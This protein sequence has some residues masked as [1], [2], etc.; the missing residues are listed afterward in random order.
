[1]TRSSQKDDERFFAQEAAKELGK[2][3][4]LGPDREI[5]DFIVTEDGN[6]F[7]LEVVE[8]FS[9][10]QDE[11]GS[12]RKGNE[13][14]T[15]KT[16]KCLREK[17]ESRDKTLL[18]VRLIGN[19]CSQN[20]D[21][22]VPT[23]LAMNLSEEPFDYQ[24]RF[25]VD[26]G[27]GKLI[28]YVTR[29][30]QH[31]RWYCVNDRCGWVD[32]IPLDRISDVIKKKGKRLPEYQKCSGLDDIRLLVVANRIMNSGKLRFDENPNLELQG[33]KIVYFYS[34]PESIH[35]FQK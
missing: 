6:Q 11:N 34:Y 15:Q 12:E 7:G 19:M 29:S 9:G 28:V 33:F 32:R 25:E 2:A 21:A 18:I 27:P 26:E 17:Y 31:A 30:I 8:I 13:S 35:V 16:V 5:P 14:K 10:S 24:D 22:V 23:L 4:R 20:L 3:W 1:M